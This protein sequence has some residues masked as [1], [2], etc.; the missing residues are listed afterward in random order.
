MIPK[1]PEPEV[2]LGRR[3]ISAMAALALLGGATI[4][5]AGCGGGGGSPSAPSAAPPAGAPPGP[6]T[7][8]GNGDKVGLVS[9]DPRHQAVITSAQLSAGGALTLDIRG[10]AGHS[11]IVELSAQEVETIRNGQR[12]MKQS[13]TTL[14]HSHL[15]TFN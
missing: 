10:S 1:K 7:G 4:T 2:D 3:Q 13:S 9:D 6:A 11:H 8:T 5:I 12:V 14:G 15:V